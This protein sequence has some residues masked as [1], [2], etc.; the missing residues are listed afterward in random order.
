MARSGFK[1]KSG[2][3]SDGSSFKVMGATPG[4]SPTKL[5]S[6]G[7]KALRYGWRALT[8]TRKVKRRGQKIQNVADETK[9]RYKYKKDRTTRNI[10][11]VETD[12]AAHNKL[13]RQKP[14]TYGV[15]DAIID[16]AAGGWMLDKFGNPKVVNLDEIHHVEPR[17]DGDTTKSHQIQYQDVDLNLPD[18]S[19]EKPSKAKSLDT[20]KLNVQKKK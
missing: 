9:K 7:L 17:D 14:I 18:P 20:I 8:G 16:G 1:L 12:V 11:N 13:V 5:I 6:L 2:N 4:E 10:K 15:S 3:I 19:D